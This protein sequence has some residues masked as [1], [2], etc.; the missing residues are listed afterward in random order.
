M[1]IVE[2]IKNIFDK[3]GK[4]PAGFERNPEFD[5]VFLTE[6][7]GYIPEVVRARNGFK[8]VYFASLE[9]DLI[10]LARKMGFRPHFHRTHRYV[11]A[12]CIYRARISGSMPKETL[13]VV[14]N[15]MA[16]YDNGIM[17]YRE[18]P[19]YQKYVANYKTKTK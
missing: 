12:R 19:E 17:T 13:A 5:A 18:N 3:S 15:L 10:D 9:P 14:N 2:C 4:L 8:Y 11:P 7:F 1:K 6:S 16:A